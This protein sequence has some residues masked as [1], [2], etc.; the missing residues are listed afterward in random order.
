SAEGGL[1]GT[2]SEIASLLGVQLGLQSTINRLDEIGGPSSEPHVPVGWAWAMDAP[3][4]WTKQVASHFGGTRNPMVVHWPKGISARGETRTQFHHVIDVVP[5]ILEAAHI[6]EPKIVNGIPQKPIEG[7]SM[8]YTFENGEA[9]GRRTTQYF[10][11]FTNRAIYHDG[12][13]AASHFGVPW[14]TQSRSGDFLNAPWELYN[15]EE[16]FSQADDLAAKHPDKLKEL[17]AL[18]LEEAQKYNVLPLDPRFAERFDPKLRVGGEPRTTWTYYGNTVWLP[19]PVGPQLFPRGHRITAELTIPTGGA[20]G[21]IACAG[22]FSAGWSLYVKDGK[23]HFRYTFFDIADVT[24]PGTVTLS[25]GKVT[26]KTEFTP[27]GS[28]EGGGIL[29]LVVNDRPAGEGQLKRSIFRHGLEPFEIGRD[30]IT[31]VDPVY[32]NKGK[33]EFTGKIE[34]VTFALQQ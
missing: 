33:F 16:D 6:A 21:V 14:D 28:K 10:E 25:E 12:W 30:S 34:K 29:K 3:F 13:V 11:M 32:K 9:K 22:A 4:Q 31:P 2:F 15:I 8:L 18:F 17:Q 23:P 5:T 26:L 7:T 1:E 24:I 20:E 27:D 19:E